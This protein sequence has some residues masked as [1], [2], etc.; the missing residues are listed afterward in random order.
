MGKKAIRKMILVL[1]A[2]LATFGVLANDLLPVTAPTQ[3]VGR[4]GEKQEAVPQTPA[5]VIAVS[6]SHKT[7]EVATVDQ[8]EVSTSVVADQDPVV[9][10]TLQPIAVEQELQIKSDTNE[11]VHETEDLIPDRPVLF[12]SDWLEISPVMPLT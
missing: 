10:E 11:A 2:L 5:T 3:A 9:E 12:T 7:T 4:S 6:G 8:A 1:F